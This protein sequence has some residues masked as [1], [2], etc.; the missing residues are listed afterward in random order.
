MKHIIIISGFLFL[1]SVAMGQLQGGF[2]ADVILNNPSDYRKHVKPLIT[3]AA[4]HH[5]SDRASSFTGSSYLFSS[6]DL[7]SYELLSANLSFTNEQN[8]AK[9]VFAP[10]K[11]NNRPVSALAEGIKF[12][13]ALQDNVATIGAAFGHDNSSYRSKKSIKLR[14]KFFDDNPIPTPEA[15]E[16]TKHGSFSEYEAH[17]LNPFTRKMMDS[18][19]LAFDESRAKSVFKW[20]AGYNIQLFPNL[21]AQG[22]VSSFDSLNAFNMKSHNFSATCTYSWDNARFTARSSY[23]QIWSRAIAAEGQK[24]VPYYGPSIAISARLFSFMKKE[25]LRKSEN[26]KKS[27][28]IPSLIFGV[29]WDGKYAD[30]SKQYV[31]YYQ[32]KIMNKTVTMPYFDILI[33]PAAQFRIGLPITNSVYPS[34]T[35]EVAGGTNIQYNLKISDLSK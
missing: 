12:N 30:G 31:P 5:L 8:N 16:V 6:I 19:L 32:D 29:S 26:Y 10:Y 22:S 23:N 25:Q 17:V 7:S 34:K 13:L 9:V 18:L 2:I 3:S 4:D 28:F 14:K 1:S 11:L 21:F 33:T 20:S 24:L 15:W 27:L 35:N